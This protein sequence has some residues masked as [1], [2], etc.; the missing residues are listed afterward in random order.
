MAKFILPILLL[1]SFAPAQA[2]PRKVVYGSD[3]RREPFQANPTLARLARST[4]AMVANRQIVNTGPGLCA[5]D[6]E[7]S[8]ETGQN[9][10]PG[11][12]FSQQP[13]GAMCSGFLVGDDLLVTAGHCL[14]SLSQ[15]GYPSAEAVC[16]GFSWVFGYGLDSAVRNPLRGRSADVYRCRQVV[17]ARLN[18]TQDFAVIRLDRKVTGRAP[19][20]FR[21]SGKVADGANLAV[22]GHPSGLPTKIA[23]GARVLHNR[24]RSVFG[25]NLDTFQG[26][27]GSAVFNT[28]SG[29][30]EGILVRGRSDY[31]P[32]ITGN[33][34]SCQVVNTPR[35]S[36][37]SPKLRIGCRG[38]ARAANSSLRGGPR[39]PSR[40][41]WEPCPTLPASSIR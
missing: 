22:I 4:A 25:T 14:L 26:N 12:R 38:R 27:S 29:E 18:N 5:L 30:V 31:R 1:S 9:V 7:E 11:E 17:V 13:I 28:A 40:L 41:H 16:R 3:N 23:D 33:A 35:S 10:C 20:R 36:R 32:S 2:A 19:L 24:D 21:A 15:I 39:G 6:F 37:G 34:N 8:L